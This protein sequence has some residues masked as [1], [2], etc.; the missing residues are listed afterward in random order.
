MADGSEDRVLAQVQLMA[1]LRGYRC[2]VVSPDEVELETERG[3][4][5]LSLDNLRM[6]V[7]QEPP[8]KRLAFLTT[9]LDHLVSTGEAPDTADDFERTRAH[10]RV[11]LYPEDMESA[12]V[13]PLRRTVVPGLAEHAVVD[14][15]T[16]VMTPG[17]THTEAWP[18]TADEIFTLGRANVRACTRLDLHS[19]DSD[20]APVYGGYLNDYASAHAL[21]LDDYPVLGRHGALVCVPV[22]GA[23]YAHP[24]DGPKLVAAQE[25][26]IKLALTRQEESP[27]RISTSIYHWHDGALTAALS[28]EPSADRDIR[29]LAHPEYQPLME[30]LI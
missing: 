9:V 29:I 13:E 8:A 28:V 1:R 14:E 10:L 12:G 30:A 7:A 11:R 5:T 24:L 6:L 4:E 18:L 3:P 25:M 26:L 23:L 20:E 27:R 21:W 16:R 2:T 15:P 17:R 22:E 19:L